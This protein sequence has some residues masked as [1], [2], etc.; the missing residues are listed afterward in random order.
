MPSIAKTFGA[1]AGL[2]A[3]AAS[4]LPSFPKLSQ[5]QMK[6]HDH[7][8]RQNAEA[9]AAGLTDIDILQL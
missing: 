8:K 5:S 7:A 2:L 6:M 3:S 9:A 1:A 4:A